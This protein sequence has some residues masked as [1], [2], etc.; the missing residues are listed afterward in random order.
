MGA[1]AV[2]HDAML[3]RNHGVITLGRTMDE[4]WTAARSWRRRRSCGFCCRGREVR[5]LSAAGGRRSGAC[6]SGSARRAL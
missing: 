2:K 3:M 1:A 5:D 4:R 6:S